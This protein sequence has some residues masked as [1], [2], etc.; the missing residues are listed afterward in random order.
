[1]SSEVPYE[2]LRLILQYIEDEASKPLENHNYETRLWSKGYRK[3]MIIIENY[4][5]NI[6]NSDDL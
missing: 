4:I 3:A 6:L 5:W 1:M 2:K